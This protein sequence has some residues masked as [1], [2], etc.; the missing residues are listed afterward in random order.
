MPDLPAVLPHPFNTQK[1]S[2]KTSISRF[3]AAYSFTQLLRQIHIFR[4]VR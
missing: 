1:G 2:L 4:F 3:Q